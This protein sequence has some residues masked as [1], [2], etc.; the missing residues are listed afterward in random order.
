MLQFEVMCKGFVGS[1]FWL[2]RFTVK[3]VVSVG[4]RVPQFNVWGE[5]CRVGLLVFMFAV[6]SMIV[7]KDASRRIVRAKIVSDSTKTGVKG[8]LAVVFKLGISY[9]ATF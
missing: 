9:R 3:V 7:V 6:F 8:G 1:V 2:V 4:L 5:A